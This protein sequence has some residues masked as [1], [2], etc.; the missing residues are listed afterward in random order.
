VI[1]IQVKHCQKTVETSQR[2]NVFTT[3][4]MAMGCQQCLPL[5]LSDVQLE[6]KHCRKP[7]C[8]NGVVD[9]LGQSPLNVLHVFIIT[10]KSFWFNLF[11]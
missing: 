3:P 6:G 1:L 8:R 11:M 9:T 5:T 7:H 4:I 2:P 10:E